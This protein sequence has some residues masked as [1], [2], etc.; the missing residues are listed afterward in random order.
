MD[1]FVSTYNTNEMP[2][3][4]HSSGQTQFRLAEI[5][6]NLSPSDEKITGLF[7]IDSEQRGKKGPVLVILAEIA[8]TLYVYEQLLDTLEQAAEQTRHLL[9]AVDTDSIVRF[10]KITQK[11]NEAIA[12]F[13]ANEPT[14]II[15]NRVNLFVME[16]SEHVLC[17]TGIGRMSS[18]FLQKQKDGRMRAFDL[19]NSLEQPA[20]INAEK[21]FSS[22]ICGD[23][24]PGDILFAGTLNFERLRQ[25]LQIKERLQTLPPVSACLEIQ[26]DLERRGIPDQ[27]CGLV[28]TNTL[29]SAPVGIPVIEAEPII[30]PHESTDSVQ[31]LHAEALKTE[32]ILSPTVTPLQDLP[33]PV[34]AWKDRFLRTRELI[35][36]KIASL[37]A[38]QRSNPVTRDPM[39]LSSLRGMS[40]G[41]GSLF[42]DERKKKIGAFAIVT[43]LVI[44]GGMWLYHARQFAAEQDLW[45]TTLNQAID[46]KNRAEGDLVYNNEDRARRLLK[47]ASDLVA[48]LDENTTDRKTAKEKFVKDL[49]EVQNKLKREVRIDQ[50]TEVFTSA[51]SG[52]GLRTL[53]IANDN[54]VSVDPANNTLVLV[55][56]T[57]KASKTL[58]LPAESP[59]VLSATVNGANVILLTEERLA[60]LAEPA[61]E[62]VG[63]ISFTFTNASSVK[64]VQAYNGRLYL[65][66]PAKNM[67]WR[68]SASGNS[69]G[70]ERGYLKQTDPAL[71]EGTSLTIDS[72]I[73]VGLAN[74]QIK[75]YLSGEESPWSVR[76]VDPALAN[77]QAMWAHAD[78][79]RIVILDRSG[80]RVLV[81]TKDGTLLTQ[82]TSER[83]N[84][85]RDV[86]VDPKTKKIYV[87]NGSSIFQLDLP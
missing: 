51:T 58:A 26:Q 46:R 67:I 2:A 43:L 83:F 27:F 3:D 63:I 47:E 50:P 71:A 66:D 7:R 59:R 38:P 44:G 31:K 87:V 61:K 62:K 41:H 70:Q 81:V 72:N 68:Y 76:N 74:G 48:S 80:K 4:P 1:P 32:S 13:V 65:L 42:T 14:P 30:D 11:L 86:T 6:I 33:R 69:Y 35:Q 82:F 15:W 8:S 78:S 54:L 52:E 84:D 22:L 64:A 36:I 25:E 79:D 12:N 29:V 20:E 34:Q 37:R 9:A 57:T 16:F 75:R 49:K 23:M 40:A 45:N 10:E 21:P 39:T 55:S 19:F 17:L 77:I 5:D 18:I 24:H 56:P 28:V 73:Y 53:S 60:L 85:L